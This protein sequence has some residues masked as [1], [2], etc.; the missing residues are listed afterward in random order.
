MPGRSVSPRSRRPRARG[1]LR[2]SVLAA[3]IAAVSRVS[4][5]IVA[6][7]HRHPPRGSAVGRDQALGLKRSESSAEVVE[8]QCKHAARSASAGASVR[9]CRRACSAT[10][11]VTNSAKTTLMPMKI[12]P[13][14]IIKHAEA[15]LAVGCRIGGRGLRAG[16]RR[17]VQLALRVSP[18][19]AASA[20]RGV[21]DE[22]R[23]H[24]KRHRWEC[25]TG[26]G[27]AADEFARS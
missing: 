24:R 11:R 26:S 10:P 9:G 4:L 23:R 21:L 2:A 5:T 18:A 15:D 27:R 20:G 1:Q 16:A 7:Q 6:A 8:G 17:V 14:R 19:T 22:Q 25:R 12:N 13:T 3:I